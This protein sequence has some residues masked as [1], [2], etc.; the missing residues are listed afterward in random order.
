MLDERGSISPFGWA[1]ACPGRRAG[2]VADEVQAL[3]AWSEGAWRRHFP[4]ERG[5]QLTAEPAGVPSGVPAGVPSEAPAQGVRLQARRG[6]FAA[7]LTIE[8][9]AARTPSV[10]MFGR[11][12]SIL[13]GQAHAL[14]ERLV[15]RA[16]VVGGAAGLGMFLSLA[17]LMIGENNPAP[18]LGG[19][20]LVVALLSAL[21]G[22]STLGGWVG[23]RL[24]DHHCDRARRE[25]ERDVGVRD[26]LRRWKA[27]SRQLTA[28]RSTLAGH[29]GQPFRSEPSALAG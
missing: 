14:G 28:Q 5:Y 16:R 12:Q 26:D 23:E 15:Q 25:R 18:M 3:V 13:L 4:P 1:I 2:Q 9:H 27:V 10:R 20:L 21:I 6:D 7:D 22:G 11:A 17:W 29:R 8:L 19:M 24:A